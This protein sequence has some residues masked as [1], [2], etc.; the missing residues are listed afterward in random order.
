VDSATILWSVS[1]P[2]GIFAHYGQPSARQE[3]DAAAALAEVRGCPLVVVVASLDLGEM[4]APSGAPGLRVVHGRNL[5]LIGLAVNAAA[6][7][8][9]TSIAIGAHAGDADYPDCRPEFVDALSRLSLAAYG[10]QVDAPLLAMSR[11][12]VVDRARQLG[13]P[14]DLCWSC[15]APDQDGRPC[16]TCNSCRQSR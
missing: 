10:V 8:G 12:D 15:Y 6:A 7:R 5:A 9:L 1:E 14:I 13:V 2:L 16:G 11:S 4:S 3:H